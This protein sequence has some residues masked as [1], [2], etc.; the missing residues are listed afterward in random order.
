MQTVDISNFNSL[1]V[2]IAGLVE[3]FGR[4]TGPVVGLAEA[5]EKLETR[6]WIKQGHNATLQRFRRIR[7]QVVHGKYDYQ[8]LDR[9]LVIIF[10]AGRL[11]HEL[12]SDYQSKIDK[13]EIKFNIKENDFDE[14]KP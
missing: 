3:E 5:I 14:K 4:L 6:N 9:D 12:W 1:T 13:S 7:N 10:A 2:S 11:T 8:L